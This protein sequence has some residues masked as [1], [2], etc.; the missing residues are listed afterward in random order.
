MLTLTRVG[1]VSAR[2]PLTLGVL[3]FPPQRG[4]PGCDPLVVGFTIT[5]GPWGNH[6]KEGDLEERSPGVCILIS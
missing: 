1:S 5:R 6:R 3:I 2:F 4:V